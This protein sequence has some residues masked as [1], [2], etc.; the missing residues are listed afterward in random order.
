MNIVEMILKYIKTIDTD[1]TILPKLYKLSERNM[2][3][4]IVLNIIVITVFYDILG[5]RLYLFLFLTPLKM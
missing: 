4:L 3:A 5:A 1:K 2:L